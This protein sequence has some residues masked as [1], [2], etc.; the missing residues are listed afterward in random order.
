MIEQ[1]DTPSI[2]P[3]LNSPSLPPSLPTFE[4][5]SWFRTSMPMGVPRVRPSTDTPE[6]ISTLSASFRGV[7]SRDWP[8][9]EGGKEGGRAVGLVSLLQQG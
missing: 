5:W 1:V 9:L 2:S 8:G 7:V 4:R 6:R 3:S